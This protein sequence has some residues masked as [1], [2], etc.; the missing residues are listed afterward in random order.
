M[1]RLSVNPAWPDLIETRNTN[2]QVLTEMLQPKWTNQCSQR[3]RLSRRNN[4]FTT[5][6]TTATATATATATFTAT[7]TATD[8][9]TAI[10]TATATVT[11]FEPTYPVGLLAQ[12]IERYTGIA[13]VMGSNP[14]SRPSFHYCSSSVHYC[15]DHFNIHVLICSSNI[16]LSHIHSRLLLLLRLPLLL[17]MIIIIV[18]IRIIIMNICVFPILTSYFQPHPIL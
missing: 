7:A 16:W 18:I 2:G 13:K 10:A 9:A 6:T 8:T 11:T 15:E 14:V 12:L 1:K 17:I 3:Q 5:A 4:N